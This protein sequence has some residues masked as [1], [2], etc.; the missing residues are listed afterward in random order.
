VRQEHAAAAVPLPIFSYF[1]KS[2]I[3][4]NQTVA[5]VRYTINKWATIA[6]VKK[7][8][9]DQEAVLKAMVKK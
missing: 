3:E 7:M 2:V 9:A 8:E 6:A 5:I 1:V 4:V